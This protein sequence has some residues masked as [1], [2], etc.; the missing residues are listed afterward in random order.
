[1]IRRQKFPLQVLN[2]VKIMQ[3]AVFSKIYSEKNVFPFINNVALKIFL[4]KIRNYIFKSAILFIS[5][6]TNV[7]NKFIIIPREIKQ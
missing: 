5:P 3:L 4:K 1:M 7:L 6:Q 2:L